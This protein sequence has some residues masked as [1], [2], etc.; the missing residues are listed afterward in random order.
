MAGV[1]VVAVLALLALLAR[2]QVV[3]VRAHLRDLARLLLPALLP[4]PVVAVLRALALRPVPVQLQAVVALAHPVVRVP[5]EVAPLRRIRSFS[6]AMAGT[7]PSPEP[8]M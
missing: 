8:P 7:S 3:V 4:A 6:A 2:L 5:G 1:V